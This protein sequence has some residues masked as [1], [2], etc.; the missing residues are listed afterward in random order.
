MQK[1]VLVFLLVAT[2]ALGA[3]GF[4]FWQ[5]N[6]TS[7]ADL[8]LEILAPDEATL[9]EEILYTVKWKNMGD[10]GFENAKLTFEYPSGALPSEG[11]EMRKITDIANIAPGQEGSMQFAARLFGKKDD[12]QEARATITYTLRNITANLRA[13]TS[14]STVLAVVPVNFELDMPSRM[15]SEQ[16]FAFTLNYSSNSAYPLS[17]LRITLEYPAGFEFRSA[18]PSPIGEKEWNIGALNQAEGGRI[19]VTGALHGNVQEAK[20]FRATLGSWKEGKFTLLRDNSK[21]VQII[22]PRLFIT[23]KINGSSDYIANAGDTLHYEV[24]FRNSSDRPLENLS[25]VVSLD[26]KPFDLTSIRA[27]G[28]NF[29]PGDN[30]ISWRPSD[31]PQLRFLGRGEEGKIEFWV[32]AQKEFRPVSPQEMN[33]VLKNSVFLSDAKE[34]FT[35]KLSANPGVEQRIIGDATPGAP[36]TEKF[37]IVEWKATNAYNDVGNVRVKATLPAGVEF[38]DDVQPREAVVT[39]DSVSKEIVWTV[40]D[41]PAGT[42][43]FGEFPA[44]LITFRVRVTNRVEKIMGEARITGEDRF[45]NRS[46]TDTAPEITFQSDSN[47]NE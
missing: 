16:Q 22:E 45:T 13:E 21:I 29:K 18:S 34:D 38:A 31:V 36:Q 20:L 4:W 15:E 44:P 47:H 3:I 19:T 23:Q 10:V 25:M 24:F 11:A 43:Y 6:S 37:Y 2:A 32:D 12:V 40:A 35:M 41:L 5:K 28:G 33:F 9:G 14:T 7:R 30:S 17:N 39:Y 42:G 46:V 1:F 26:G 27:D 8:K